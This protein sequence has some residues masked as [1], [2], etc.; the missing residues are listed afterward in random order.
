MLQCLRWG[1]RVEQKTKVSW[2]LSLIVFLAVAGAFSLSLRTPAPGTDQGGILFACLI[3]ALVAAIGNGKLQTYIKR[4]DF[5]VCNGRDSGQG[6]KG[7]GSGGRAFDKVG[8]AAAGRQRTKIS[9]WQE[10]KVS[11]AD[12]SNREDADA[13][14]R[15][16]QMSGVCIGNCKACREPVCVRADSTRSRRSR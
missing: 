2:I 5:E 10:E 16:V 11:Q 1:D 7:R 3:V 4:S 6:Y 13:S 9:P 14:Q 8:A 15:P 12:T